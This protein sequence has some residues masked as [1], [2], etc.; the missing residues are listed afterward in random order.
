MDNS[1]ESINQIL[2]RLEIL[3]LKIDS[4]LDNIVILKDYQKMNDNKISNIEKVI[5]SIKMDT[6][7]YT[8]ELNEIKKDTKRMDDHITFVEDTMENVSKYLSVKNFNPLDAIKTPLKSF[9]NLSLF[10]SIKDNNKEYI[11]RQIKQ[12]GLDPS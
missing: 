4:V 5:N 8:S 6:G 10:N 3:S 1:K 7:N 11:E 12:D 9:S 2:M